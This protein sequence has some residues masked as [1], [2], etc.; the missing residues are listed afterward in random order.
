M[1]CL[2]NTELSY[3]SNL[4]SALL[5]CLAPCILIQ[6]THY[7]LYIHF[8]F[9][10]DVSPCCLCFFCDFCIHVESILIWVSEQHVKLRWSLS[11]IL[12]PLILTLLHQR[13][14][15]I[16]FILIQNRHCHLPL[17]LIMGCWAHRLRASW[18]L[19]TRYELE[20]EV[21]EVGDL[22]KRC[23]SLADE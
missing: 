6:Y 5:H 20:A 1:K 14:A 18:Q 13:L 4:I 12:F 17:C 9:C 15:V 21:R 3:L 22:V 10:M 16:W 19:E 23:S 8:I 2:H 7:T 11:L